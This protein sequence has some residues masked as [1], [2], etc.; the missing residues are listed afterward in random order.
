M[1]RRVKLLVE[2]DLGTNVGMF[3]KPENWETYLSLLLKDM[4]PHYHPTVKL[5]SVKDETK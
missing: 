5:R 4:C 3:Y 1:K 2:V